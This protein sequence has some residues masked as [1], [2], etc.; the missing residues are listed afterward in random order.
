MP[1][2]MMLLP[3]RDSNGAAQKDTTIMKTQ[4]NTNVTG[5]KRYTCRRENKGAGFYSCYMSGEERTACWETW[6]YMFYISDWYCCPVSANT[7]CKSCSWTSGADEK[8]FVLRETLNL[9][10]TIW[11]LL[12][13]EQSKH[14]EDVTVYSLRVVYLIKQMGWEYSGSKERW[15]T[16]V[17]QGDIPTMKE[18]QRAMLSV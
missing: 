6:M 4:P 13:R 17:N 3:T 1:V 5:M 12:L 15:K 11:W 2:R 7:V 9:D 18:K 10:S 16:V 14:K 8:S